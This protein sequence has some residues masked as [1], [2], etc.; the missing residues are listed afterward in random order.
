MT[1]AQFLTLLATFGT[2]ALVVIPVVRP[3]VKDAR[4]VKA[5]EILEKLASAAVGSRVQRVVDLKDPAKPGY[6][7]PAAA[8][9]TKQSAVDDVVVQ[10]QRAVDT[11]RKLG[12]ERPEY[13]IAQMIESAVTAQKATRPPATAAAAVAPAMPASV[14]QTGGNE[15]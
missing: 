14:I 12:V 10:G 6:W 2:V 13:L 7:S 8:I 9:S 11:L 15:P 3:Y 5:L 1:F 4:Y